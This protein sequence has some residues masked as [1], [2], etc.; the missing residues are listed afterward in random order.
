MPFTAVRERTFELI[1]TGEYVFTLNYLTEEPGG[2]YGDAMRWEWLIALREDPT[3][4]LCRSDGNERTLRV[5]TG[6]DIVI[7]GQAHEWIQV[8]TGRTFEDGADPPDENE[9]LGRRMIAYLTHQAPKKGPNAGKLREKIVAGSA[10][11]FKG[12]Q[13]NKTVAAPMKRQEPTEAERERAELVARVEK[14]I[15]KAVNLSTPHHRDYVAVDLNAASD[16]ELLM[17]FNTVKAEVTAALDD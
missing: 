6:A 10:K 17:L 7:G 8:L 13:P 12:P 15:G 1:E 4:Y 11:P 3:G 5:W 2:Q 16:D 14:Q 9:L